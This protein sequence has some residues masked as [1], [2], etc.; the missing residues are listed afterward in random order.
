MNTLPE[1]FES[2]IVDLVPVSPESLQRQVNAIQKAM[3]QVMKE[4]THYGVIPGCK[5]KSLYKAGA[6]KINL[7]FRLVPEFS[8]ETNNLPNGHLEIITT[9]YLH[10]SHLKGP[11][12]GQG[13]GSASTLESKHRYRSGEGQD[14]GVLVP[15][16]Y[17]TNRD[18]SLIGGK[19]HMAKK[20]DGAWHVFKMT[21][22]VE[23]P[24][25]A[26]QYNTVRKMSKKRSMVDAT[27]TAT[28]AS[29]I[30]TQDIEDMPD[31]DVTP[32]QEAPKAQQQE[33]QKPTEQA[34]AETDDVITFGKHKGERWDN[35]TNDYLNWMVS[36]AKDVKYSTR[37]LAELDRRKDNQTIPSA[38]NDDNYNFPTEE[39]EAAQ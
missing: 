16:E 27:I 34:S 8:F 2:A 25:I 12:V 21:E 3:E 37:A 35:L 19:G 13:V 14:T 38:W 17:W 5:E 18:I 10:V 30:F 15:K 9:C 7:L 6:E 31:L 26:D 39:N 32:T 28:A 24:D 1:V 29:D 22:K 33:A 20:V 36:N 23:N 11:I 4:G